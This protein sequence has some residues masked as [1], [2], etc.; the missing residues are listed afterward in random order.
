[1]IQ[2]IHVD[3]DGTFSLS[4]DRN[5]R[6]IE[7]LAAE[8]GIYADKS[9]KK[10]HELWKKNLW[11]MCE[12]RAEPM[13]HGILVEEFPESRINTISPEDFEFACKIFY[14]ARHG[15]VTIRP[16][17]LEELDQPKGQG[18]KIA[19]VTSS[20]LHSTHM[21]LELAFGSAAEGE[22][23]FDAI[24]TSDDIANVADR[25]PSPVPFRKSCHKLELSPEWGDVAMEDSPTGRDSALA[26]F[27]GGDN[28]VIRFIEADNGDT[29]DHGKLVHVH[30]M[31]EAESRI[32]DYKQELQKTAASLPRREAK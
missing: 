31:E 25:K 14:N 16:G 26:C 24:V 17:M 6:V 3:K 10:R 9:V 28:L 22:R 8:H 20:D 23:F 27:G 4:E 30:N 13:I 5:K 32:Q 29:A 21:D 7:D 11:G 1:M 2:A 19:M 12:G 15:E 18:V